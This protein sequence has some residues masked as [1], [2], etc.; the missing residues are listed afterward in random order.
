MNSRYILRQVYNIQTNTER[1]FQ[2]VLRTIF[3]G[4]CV[5]CLEKNHGITLRR[6]QAGVLATIYTRELRL[7]FPVEDPNGRRAFLEAIQFLGLFRSLIKLLGDYQIR[8]NLQGP[9]RDV[10]EARRNLTTFREHYQ[11]ATKTDVFLVEISY[12]NYADDDVK[13][14]V[15]FS[16]HTGEIRTFRWTPGDPIVEEPYPD[17]W[18]FLRACQSLDDVY[19]AAVVEEIQKRR[20]TL[21]A[22]SDIAWRY[23]N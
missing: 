20:K 5:Q 11:R 17:A 14:E 2:D 23:H 6:I 15:S 3:Q 22:L 8:E 21:D 16:S 13:R 18:D 12:I 19:Q 1:L 10:E 4:H 9:W 7:E